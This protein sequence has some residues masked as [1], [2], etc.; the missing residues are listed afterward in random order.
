M[1]VTF[2]TQ[3]K[4]VS[5]GQNIKD[6]L[7]GWPSW[8]SELGMGVHFKELTGIALEETFIQNVDLKGKCLLNYSTVCMVLV[9][10]LAD[11]N[12]GEN[13]KRC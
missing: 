1:T 9:T 5:L 4:Q 7:R 2:Y 10:L 3:H 13:V 11:C 12:Q 6:L 8:F